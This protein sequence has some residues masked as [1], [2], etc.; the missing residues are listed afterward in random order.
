M[1]NHYSTM[2]LCGLLELLVL[3]SCEPPECDKNSDCKQG[4]VCAKSTSSLSADAVCEAPSSRVC[5]TKGDCQT[6]GT[7]GNHQGVEYHWIC[8][9]EH[10]LIKEDVNFYSD[11]A[12]IPENY[13]T[14]AESNGSC[15]NLESMDCRITNIGNCDV[16]T[17]E[18]V[19]N[20]ECL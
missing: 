8:E 1:K 2:L 9:R 3:Y 13:T 10:C 6:C 17:E 5:A 11:N 19:E 18:Y 15:T 7:P 4:E 12:G 20:G 16:E 14:C